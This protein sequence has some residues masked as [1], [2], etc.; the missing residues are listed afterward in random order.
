M[1]ADVRMPTPPHPTSK[2]L[3]IL[4]NL[5][6]VQGMPCHL[7]TNRLLREGVDLFLA[8]GVLT[9]RLCNLVKLFEI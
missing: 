1:F 7:F 5:L 8:S 6:A 4:T 2:H 9:A 3:T